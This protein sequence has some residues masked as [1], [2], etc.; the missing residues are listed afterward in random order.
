[1]ELGSLVLQNT[2]FCPQ[3]ICVFRVIAIIYLKSINQLV[4]T[5]KY[6]VFPMRYELNF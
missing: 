2:A 1:M 5:M 4:F 6:D 3:R